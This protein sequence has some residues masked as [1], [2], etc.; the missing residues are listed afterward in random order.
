MA[1]E[2]LSKEV[3]RTFHAIV[4]NL[5]ARRLCDI[6]ISPLR[7]EKRVEGFNLILVIRK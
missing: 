6:F 5:K 2:W 4:I 1:R 7:G 3:M